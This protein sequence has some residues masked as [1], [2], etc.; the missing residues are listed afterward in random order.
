MSEGMEKIREEHGPQKST[1]QVSDGLTAT[2][3]AS[4]RPAW[5]CTYMLGLLVWV[6]WDSVS[7]TLVC[8]WDCLLPIGLS[9]LAS[10]PGLITLSHRILFCP[11]WLLSLGDLL[12][13]KMEKEGS[14]PEGEAVVGGAGRSGG[15]GNSGR[16]VVCERGI[17][18]QLKKREKKRLSSHFY[19]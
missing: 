10:I 9:C 2:E 4:T 3:V 8:S 18:F 7:L 14:G 12:F 19:I 17:Y 11:A 6:L 1:K 16:D 15:K 5:V 13:S